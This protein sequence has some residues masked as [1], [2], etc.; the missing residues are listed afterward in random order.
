MTVKS[1]AFSIA[2]AAALVAGSASAD[3]PSVKVGA[4]EDLTGPTARYG[5]AIKNGFELAAEQINAK[6][7][8]LQGRK[9]EMLFEDA[10]GQKDQ[11]IT[12][13]KKLIARDKVVALLGPTLSNEMFA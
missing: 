13:G 6:G 9:I 12:A 3:E 5:V 1:R 11:A 2:V 7:G 10:A 8:V 4:I